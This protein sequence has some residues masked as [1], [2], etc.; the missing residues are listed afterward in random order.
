MRSNTIDVVLQ[1]SQ[2]LGLVNADKFLQPFHFFL[3][4][5][6]NTQRFAGE[7]AVKSITQVFDTAVHVFDFGAKQVA[8]SQDDKPVVVE[9]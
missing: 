9:V 4:E 1:G 2:H 3:V 5:G 8:S 7:N 6:L